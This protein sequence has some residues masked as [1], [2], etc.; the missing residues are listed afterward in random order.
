MTYIGD[1]GREIYWTYAWAPAAGEGNNRVPAENETLAGVYAKYDAY[2][3]PRK[4][5]IRAAVAF[6]RRKQEAN[7]RFDNF[8]TAL[9][10]LVKN[11]G[12]EAMEDRMVRDAIVLRAHHP[13]VREKCLDMGDDLTLEKS[14]SIGQNHE[15]TLETQKA[16]EGDEDA[17]V[18]T[19]R[20]KRKEERASEME[21]TE[22]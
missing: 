1:K 21:K 6:N 19:V 9:K 12:Y 2:V 10:I 4:D 13:A 14:V 18:H 16:I 5:Q 8:V 17:K 7:E 3:A 15:I 22:Q 11:C 20:E